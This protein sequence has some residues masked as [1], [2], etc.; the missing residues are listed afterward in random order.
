MC[1]N[2][3]RFHTSTDSRGKVYVVTWS[4]SW[5]YNPIQ[6]CLLQLYYVSVSSTDVLERVV[7]CQSMT[8]SEHVS[9]IRLLLLTPDHTGV[10]VGW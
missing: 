2:V 1:S 3:V 7:M 8:M 5:L 4:D 10:N 6:C 9:S